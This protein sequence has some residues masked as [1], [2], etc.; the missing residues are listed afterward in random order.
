MFPEREGEQNTKR[1]LCHEERGGWEMIRALLTI[2]DIPSG[3]TCAIVDYLNE[4]GDSG[5]H[6]RGGRKGGKEPGTCGICGSA[7]NDRRKP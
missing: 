1:E 6:V 5:R 7:W 3:N 4:A 2:D